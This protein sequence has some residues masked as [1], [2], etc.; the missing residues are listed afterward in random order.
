M[1]RIRF[2]SDD[3][4]VNGLY[5]LALHGRVRCLPDGLFETQQ[6]MLDHLDREGVR[7]T[8]VTGE[9]LGEADQVRN[10]PAVTV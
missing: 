6:H 5:C 7:Y 8:I 9:T 2:K 1:V 10:T 4:H 3:D